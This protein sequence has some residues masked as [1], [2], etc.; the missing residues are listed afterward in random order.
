MPITADLLA[1]AGMIRF[2][3]LDPDPAARA[4]LADRLAD[5]AAELEP[6]KRGRPSSTETAKLAGIADALMLLRGVD[7]KVAVRAA[8]GADES[9][10]SA[11]YKLLS[12]G[13][14]D[15]QQHRHIL[16]VPVDALTQAVERL[17]KSGPRG[18]KKR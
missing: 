7:P 13:R 3:E 6:A 16:S 10:Y 15:R 14:R 12:R 2:G 11:V 18:Q 4:R 17:P 9:A 1:A 8:I 5:L